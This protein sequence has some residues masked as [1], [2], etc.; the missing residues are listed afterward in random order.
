MFITL[1]VGMYSCKKPGVTYETFEASNLRVINGLTGPTKNVKFY[2][3]SFNLSLTGTL[4]YGGVSAYWVVKT[5]IKSASL[6]N[7]TTKETF[8]KKDIQLDSKKS[9]TLFIADTLGSPKYFLTEDNLSQ[10]ASADKAK[11]RLANL[12]KTGGNVD[13]TFQLFDNRT[14]P[15]YPPGPEVTVYTNVPAQTIA[16]YKLITV[17]TSKG[18]TSPQLYTIRV[19]ETGTNNLLTFTNGADLRGPATYTIVVRGVKNGTAP[20]G[21]AITTNLEWLDW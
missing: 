12:A 11:V 6:Y 14:I 17:P 2:L 20:Y 18:N 13:V 8:A 1:S 15:Q 19:Y 9:Y 16:D 7:T 10:P 3:D 5:G 21:L 4:N